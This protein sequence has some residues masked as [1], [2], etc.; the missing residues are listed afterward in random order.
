MIVDFGWSFGM[1]DG[2]HALAIRRCCYTTYVSDAYS[3]LHCI[4]IYRKRGFNHSPYSFRKFALDAELH[5]GHV[6]LQYWKL[7][8]K[9]CMGTHLL[10]CCKKH[11][12][13]QP[14]DFTGCQCIDVISTRKYFISPFPIK[15]IL[16]QIRIPFRIPG[17]ICCSKTDQT[18]YC[19]KTCL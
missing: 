14:R 6:W 10:E 1:N 16:S 17:Y 15:V 3:I 8:T 5:Y 7:S 11:S 12:I 4:R 2:F 19:K 13:Q 9:Q 18:Q